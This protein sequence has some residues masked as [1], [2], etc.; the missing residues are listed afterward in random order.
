MDPIDIN[1]NIQ[2]KLDAGFQGSLKSGD[3]VYI[4]VIKKVAV[5]KWA[6]GIHGKTVPA[7]SDIELKTGDII[8][9]QVFIKGKAIIL[10]LIED[11]QSLLQEKLNQQGITSDKLS[12]LIISSLI[13][14]GLAVDAHII[15][16]IKQ[17]L[18]TV[19]KEDR[20]IISLIVQMFKKGI[21]LD[22][23][24]IHELLSLLNY[25]EKR[26]D[27]KEHKR[28]QSE[29]KNTIKLEKA[30]KESIARRDDN[31]HNILG[32]FNQLKTGGE[33]WI[34]IPYDFSLEQ[35]ALR[36]TIRVLFDAYN[37]KVLKVCVIVWADEEQRWSFFIDSETKPKTMTIYSNKRQ[38]LK[39][40]A[41]GLHELALKL[42]NN[43]VKIDDIKFE[44]EYFDGFYTTDELKYYKSI[45]TLQ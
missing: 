6:I 3:F 25:G 20:G 41:K 19:K 34:I 40:A 9:A 31:I 14:G 44:D 15:S 4:S 1:R 23:P 29:F 38:M 30:I 42:D 11:R 27:N 12:L 32:L 37:K 28:K 8:K 7:Y 21:S 18:K 13:K 2:I 22:S 33:N 10:K 45:D 43:S 39:K 16:K 35:T 36:G 26:K 17:L 5:N 24:Q